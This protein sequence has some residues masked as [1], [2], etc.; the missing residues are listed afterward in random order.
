MSL[1]FCKKLMLFP[2]SSVY[3]NDF[4]KSTLA[5]SDYEGYVAVWDTSCGRKVVSHHEHSKR[6]WSVVYNP[7]DPN[8]FASGSDDCTGTYRQL[9][10]APVLAIH[11]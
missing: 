7:S 10:Q 5:S 4:H 3:Y 11:F 1:P 8:V 6:V 2:H 9:M